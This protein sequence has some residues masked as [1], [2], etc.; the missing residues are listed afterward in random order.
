MLIT[1]HGM[2]QYMLIA[3]HAMYTF[4]I[5]GQSDFYSAKRFPLVGSNRV[6]EGG[7]V[8]QYNNP[9]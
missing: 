1:V 6:K 7:G 5:I 2:H 4:C 9:N 8:S 3:V